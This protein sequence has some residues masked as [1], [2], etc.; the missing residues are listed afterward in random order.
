VHRTKKC[1]S[2]TVLS[3]R[4]NKENGGSLPPFFV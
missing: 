3:T 2:S 1:P 4:I